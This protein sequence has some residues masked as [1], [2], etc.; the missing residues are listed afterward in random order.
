MKW[1]N[2]KEIRPQQHENVLV[3]MRDGT[4][5]GAHYIYSEWI[6][7]GFYPIRIKPFKQ[8]KYLCRCESENI[9]ADFVE[10]PELWSRIEKDWREIS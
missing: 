7:N 10:Q 9:L 6:P 2:I 5:T 3:K 8:Y 1:N 4:I